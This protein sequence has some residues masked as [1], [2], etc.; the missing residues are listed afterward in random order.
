MRRA[1]KSL[2][3]SITTMYGVLGSFVALKDMINVNEESRGL[4]L[5]FL[6]CSGHYMYHLL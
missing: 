1:P 6:N 4:A 5:R 3:A 2:L